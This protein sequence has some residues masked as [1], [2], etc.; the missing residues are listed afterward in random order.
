[1]VIACIVSTASRRPGAK[2][3]SRWVP[4]PEM[5][6]RRRRPWRTTTPISPL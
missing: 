4:A 1:M 2:S 3:R 5:N 6:T